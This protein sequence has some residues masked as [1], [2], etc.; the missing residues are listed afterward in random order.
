MDIII[1]LSRMSD[2][3][4]KIDLHTGKQCKTSI[5]DFLYIKFAHQV[6]RRITRPIV[7]VVPTSASMIG[8]YTQAIPR[9]WI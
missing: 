2:I 1:G 7:V 8:L 3:R 4:P 9:M 5:A 6:N